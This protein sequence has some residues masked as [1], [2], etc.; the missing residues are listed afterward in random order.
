MNRKVTTDT[1]ELSDGE[2]KSTATDG[3]LLLTYCRHAN[4]AAFEQVV[5]RHQRLVLSVCRSVLR[6][7]QDAEDAFQATFLILSRR[8]GSLQHAR[9]IAGWLYRVALRTAMTA[10]KR[11]VLHPVESGVIE[12]A[13][14]HEAFRAIEQQELVFALNEELANLPEQLRTPLVLYHLDGRTRIEIA[15]QL[16]TTV[17]AIK[18]RLARAKAKLRAKLSQRGVSYSV[19]VLSLYALDNTTTEAALIDHTVHLCTAEPFTIGSS[20]VYQ[21]ITNLAH[22]GVRNM[23]AALTTRALTVAAVLSIIL[24]GLSVTA[25]G[26]SAIP[27][28]EANLVSL[29]PTEPAKEETTVESTHL[30]VAAP[31][32]LENSSEISTATNRRAIQ[33]LIAALRDQSDTVRRHAAYV[34]GRIGSESTDATDALFDVCI[35]PIGGKLSDANLQALGK[36]INDSDYAYGLLIGLIN[37]RE[38]Q[39]IGLKIA[40][41]STRESDELANVAIEVLETDEDDD[42]RDLAVTLIQRYTTP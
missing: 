21:S 33:A 36:L 27:I 12:L 18:S 22:D 31:I 25:P 29:S 24:G 9:S 35:N 3:E 13:H 14:E 11:R 1:K 19:A 16:G 38:H 5:R 8:A 39:H 40:S 26:Q 15:Q 4:E 20:N 28:P 32:T 34:L 41:F 23:S 6:A 7:D 17:E 42:V 30:V 2:T 37:S 10:R